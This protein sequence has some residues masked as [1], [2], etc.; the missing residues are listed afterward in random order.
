MKR[1]LISLCC[2][3][4]MLSSCSFHT[5]NRRT[6]YIVSG[7]FI[8]HNEDNVEETY[9]L[10]LINI[11]EEEFLKANG[12]NVIEDKIIKNYY[13]ILFYKIDENEPIYYEFINFK[14][15]FNG[16]KGTPIVYESDNDW[17]L[18]P[19]TNNSYKTNPYYSVYNDNQQIY[20]FCHLV[21][22]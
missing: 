3:L 22:E 1:L 10:K 4:S 19:H 6:N 11:S 9:C 13:R 14:D 8:G 2:L 12:L 20:V 18:W 17:R 21:N 5:I 7:T 16:A 15:A